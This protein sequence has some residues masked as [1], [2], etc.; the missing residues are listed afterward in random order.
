MSSIRSKRECADAT[1]CT[2]S[3]NT[4]NASFVNNSTKRARSCSTGCRMINRSVSTVVIA[5]R[6]RIARTPPPWVW[7]TLAAVA[8][9][10]TV[11]LGRMLG[12][13]RR[14]CSGRPCRAGR[15]VRA[16]QAAWEPWARIS[17]SPSSLGIPN[18]PHGRGGRWSPGTRASTEPGAFRC[19]Q[20]AFAGTSLW[21]T[22]NAFCDADGCAWPGA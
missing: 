21:S 4:V 13:S 8:T 10:V 7:C 6:L 15:V 3:E 14:C 12:A 5:G 19:P 17:G 9:I 1:S 2:P 22:R 16:A 20:P 18:P 11:A